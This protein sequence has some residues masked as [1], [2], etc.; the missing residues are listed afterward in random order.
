MKKTIP[1]VQRMCI[2]KCGLNDVSEMCKLCKLCKPR[3]HLRLARSDESKNATKDPDLI[4]GD[5]EGAI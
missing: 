1:L 3:R 5:V 2:K 4:H